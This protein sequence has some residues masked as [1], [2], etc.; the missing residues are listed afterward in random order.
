MGQ[1]A[2]AMADRRFAVLLGPSAFP[3]SATCP[4]GRATRGVGVGFAL[5]LC[6]AMDGPGADVHGLGEAG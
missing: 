3:A 1:C 5:A 2:F 6:G 4:T